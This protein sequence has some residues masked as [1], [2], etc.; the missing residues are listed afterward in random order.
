MMI[1]KGNLGER[2]RRIFER[3]MEEEKKDRQLS[4]DDIRYWHY[5]PTAEMVIK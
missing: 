2:R 4:T 3:R 5:S 1:Q